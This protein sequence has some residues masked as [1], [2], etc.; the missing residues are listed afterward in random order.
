MSDL[1]TMQN[2]QPWTAPYSD[3]FEASY[4]A[5]Q[6]RRLTHDLLH[7]T[8][9]VG[10]LASIAEWADH[11]RVRLDRVPQDE[12]EGRV[13]DLVMCALHI[14]NNPPEG[15]ERFDLERAVITRTEAVNGCG[16]G[17]A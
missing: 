12:Y 1:A 5:E 8:K 14:A 13:A 16:F 11:G 7:I 10:I 9:A 2:T 6:H 4:D 17:D 15:Y 3:A